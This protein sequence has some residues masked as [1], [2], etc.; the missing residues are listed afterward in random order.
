MSYER[1]GQRCQI[2]MQGGGAARGISGPDA[3]GYLAGNG[4]LTATTYGRLAGLA[5]VADLD[6]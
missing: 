4:L 3:S 6:D 2:C 1:M 5:A